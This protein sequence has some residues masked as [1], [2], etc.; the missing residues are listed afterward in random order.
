MPE[1]QIDPPLA[2]LGGAV[3]AAPEW[4]LRNIAAPVERFSVEVGGTVIDCRAW[5]ERG[6]PGLV[7]LHGNAAHLAWWSFLLPF[8]A[9]THRVVTFSLSGMGESGWRETYSTEDYLHEG[10]AAAEAGG[11]C[12][13]GPPIVIGHSAGGMPVLGMAAR[14]PD[15]LRA[16]ILVDTGLPGDEMDVAPPRPRGRSY[17]EIASALARFRLSPPQPCANLYIADFIAR[18]GLEQR[19]NGEYAWRFDHRL[20]GHLDFGDTWGDLANARVPLAIVRGELSELTGGR[21]G[22]RVRRVAPAGTVFVD[23]P[24]AYHHVM[25]DQPLALTATLRT[26]IETWP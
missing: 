16:A 18:H 9:P 12:L 2:A 11:A 6:R 15:R 24:E 10:L 3:P 23:I 19:D 25:I 7:F 20:F 1:M 21:M 5:G 4:F 8:F 22:A 13:E 17:P 26:L 14:H